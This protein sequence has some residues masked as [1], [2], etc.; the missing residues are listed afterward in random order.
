[1]YW[2]N[3]LVVVFGAVNLVMTGA[4]FAALAVWEHDRDASDIKP[5]NTAAHDQA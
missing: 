4:T 1:M 5:A 2:A 3:D